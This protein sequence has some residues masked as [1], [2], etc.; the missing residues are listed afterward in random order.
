M[1]ARELEVLRLIS[2]GLTNQQ[3]ADQLFISAGTV[4]THVKNIY[5]KLDVHNRVQ[6]V[7]RAQALNLL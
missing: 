7:E 2:G 1:T 3:I 6:A 5:G 4:K